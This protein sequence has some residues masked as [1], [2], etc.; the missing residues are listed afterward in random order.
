MFL[1]FNTCIISAQNLQVKVADVGAGLCVIAEI[2]N[3]QDSSDPY[4][5]LYD[6]GRGCLD[7]INE[8]IPEEQPIDLIVLSHNDS[9][10]I[11]DADKVLDEY[12]VK[13]ILW[14]GFQRPDIGQWNE[15]NEA[16]NAEHPDELINLRVHQL[17]IGS[18]WVY[19][20]TYITFVAGF[21][22]PPPQW[23]FSPSEE[24]E[25]RNAGSIVM[26]IVHG[27]KSILLTGDMIGRHETDNF[28]NNGIIAAEKFVV[29]N[30]FAVP[31]DSDLLVASHHGGNDASSIPFIESV[32]PEYVIFPSGSNDRYGHPRSAVAQRFLDSGVLLHNIFRTDK[33]DDESH[34][35]HWEPD[36]VTGVVDGSGDDSVIISITSEGVISVGYEN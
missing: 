16:I 22:V 20:E 12:L 9:D 23:G 34:A 25:Y 32:N 28:P 33:E 24:S 11:Y 1:I 2:P 13:K 31:I 4:Y 26:R 27:Q 35:G 8:M 14:S 17:P 29:A 30:R 21:H 7:D 6:V 36:G 19:G 18:T 10:H 5:M 3:L 15:L